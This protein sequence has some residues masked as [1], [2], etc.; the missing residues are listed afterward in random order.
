MGSIREGKGTRG[1][2]N[3]ERGTDRRK[4]ESGKEKNSAKLKRV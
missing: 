1:R 3:R 2:S 4:G